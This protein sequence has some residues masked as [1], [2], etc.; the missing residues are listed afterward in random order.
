MAEADL[1][2]T[3]RRIM[4][5]ITLNRRLA[6][7]WKAEAGRATD[8]Q[9]QLQCHERYRFYGQLAREKA[10]ELLAGSDPLATARVWLRGG[11]QA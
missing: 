11:G 4:A 10:G 7:E 8:T 5:A 1:F 2:Q 9:K 3:Q 6:E